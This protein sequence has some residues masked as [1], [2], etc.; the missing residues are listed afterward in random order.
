MTEEQERDED[1]KVS[2]TNY[3]WFDGR[4]QDENELYVRVEY[5]VW[6]SMHGDGGLEGGWGRD[7]RCWTRGCV[8]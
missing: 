6:L 8:G 2:C 3:R 4:E 1:S 5:R 7:D